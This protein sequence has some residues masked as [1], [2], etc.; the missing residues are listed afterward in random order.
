MLKI[1]LFVEAQKGDIHLKS[2]QNQVSF[3]IFDKHFLFSSH[4][5]PLNLRAIPFSKIYLEVSLQRYFR[6]VGHNKSSFVPCGI[7]HFTW[8]HKLNVPNAKDVKQKWMWTRKIRSKARNAQAVCQLVARMHRF[9]ELGHKYCN[10]A[11]IK[12]RFAAEQIACDSN[13]SISFSFPSFPQ[14]RNKNENK[15]RCCCCC[16][17]RTTNT[18]IIVVLHRLHDQFRT[19]NALMWY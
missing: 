7:R 4:E 19:V 11:T 6:L 10:S 18:D 2:K 5:T 14:I 8:R 12:M 3:E 17:C 13:T 16:C 9:C 1:R 15:N